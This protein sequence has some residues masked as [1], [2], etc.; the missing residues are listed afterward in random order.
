[1]MEHWVEN[2]LEAEGQG[3]AVIIVVFIRLGLFT[4]IL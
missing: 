3:G 4:F 1:M 2:M